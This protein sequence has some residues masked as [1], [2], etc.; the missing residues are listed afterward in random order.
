MLLIT[1]MVSWLVLDKNTLYLRIKRLPLAFAVAGFWKLAQLIPLIWEF[2][3]FDLD[4]IIKLLVFTSYIEALA[5]LFAVS[6]R[7]SF[8]ILSISL[9]IHSQC[10]Q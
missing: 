9:L 8:L 1:S 4:L 3:T 2:D 10:I 5:V 7:Q 6:Y